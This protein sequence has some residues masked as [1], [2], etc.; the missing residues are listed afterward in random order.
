[1]K[2]T[3]YFAGG[4]LNYYTAQQESKVN[5]K[6][7]TQCTGDEEWMVEDEF[8][9]TSSTRVIHL[10]CCNQRRVGGMKRP[11]TAAKDA[12]AVRGEIFSANAIGI[13]ALARVQQCRIKVEDDGQQPRMSLNH[14]PCSVFDPVN[15]L[16]YESITQPCNSLSEN[17]MGNALVNR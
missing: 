15:I 12:I 6:D 14:G 16:G 9:D 2:S 4:N 5:G 11:D 1:M 13:N 10:Y 3:C 8:T 7:Y 17:K